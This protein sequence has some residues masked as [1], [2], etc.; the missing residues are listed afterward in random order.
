M[1]MFKSL[2][3]FLLD[4]STPYP[5]ASGSSI[6]RPLPI[7]AGVSSLPVPDGLVLPPSVGN[8]SSSG[9]ATRS[10]PEEEEEADLLSNFFPKDC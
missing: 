4:L 10:Q 3:K 7:G 1:F 5:I 6:Q 9:G 2:F 8:P